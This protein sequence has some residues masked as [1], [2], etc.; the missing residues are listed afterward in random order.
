M[1]L[2]LGRS[3]GPTEV[4]PFIGSREQVDETKSAC[5]SS[6]NLVMCGLAKRGPLT[7]IFSP[8]RVVFAISGRRTL[9]PKS[10]RSRQMLGDQEPCTADR[11][12]RSFRLRP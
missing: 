3:V 1:N 7:L 10:C 2:G 12:S 5:S 6:F 11:G 4:S 9:Q 8:S